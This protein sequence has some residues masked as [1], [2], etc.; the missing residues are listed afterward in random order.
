[1][2]DGGEYVGKINDGFAD[3]RGKATWKN[4]TYVKNGIFVYVGDWNAG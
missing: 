1:L 4:N 2:D 3:G